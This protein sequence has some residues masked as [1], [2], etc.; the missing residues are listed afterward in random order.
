MP[1]RFKV[2]TFQPEDAAGVSHLF[3]QVYGDGYPVKTVYNPQEIISAYK[4][5]G[6]F[7]FVVRSSATSVI[8]F[9]ALYH[10]APHQGIYE[11]GQGVVSPEYRSAGLGRM[12][13]EYVEQYLPTLPGAELYFG[14][15]V[16]NHTHTQ[17]AGALIK[18]IETGI[19]IDLLPG[20]AYG[21]TAQS[22]NRVAVVDMFRTYVPSPHAV[23]IPE[24]Y[25][26]IVRFIYDGFDD[27]RTLL[28]SSQPPVENQSTQ[29]SSRVFEFAQVA[30]IGA[31]VIGPD[32]EEKLAAEEIALADSP[33][34]VKQLW[35][36]LSRPGAAWAADIL[37]QHGYFFGGIFPR[38]FGE[39]ALLMQHING[40]P[41]WD[42]IHLYSERSV[43][44]Y[45]HIQADWQSA[46]D[47]APDQRGMQN[48]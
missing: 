10:S 20:N 3:N 16:C 46:C 48:G 7:P 12:L 36:P 6:Y 35:L 26:Q 15:A 11:F 8:A 19:E 45:R 9:G 43:E 17:K 13:F 42:S 41:E 47:E 23:Y 39:D 40:L 14:E 18:T 28:L 37:R 21:D 27:S 5:G 29:L 24:R 25:E 4:Q 32:F 38:W 22:H 2:E 30:R 33:L 44:I 31:P 1:F 34:R